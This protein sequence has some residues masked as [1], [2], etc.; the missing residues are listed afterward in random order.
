M[1]LFLELQCCNTSQRLLFQTEVEDNGMSPGADRPESL[2]EP[3][4][5]GWKELIL[6]TFHH[7]IQGHRFGV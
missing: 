7:H 3:A 4:L 2:L 6:H 5:A 1:F